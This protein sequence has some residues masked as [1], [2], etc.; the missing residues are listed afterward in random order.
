MALNALM[1][2][3]AAVFVAATLGVA[4]LV[5]G[6]PEDQP[7]AGVAPDH[8]INLQAAATELSPPTPPVV[9]GFTAPA[10]V[11]EKVLQAGPQVQPPATASDFTAD[12]PKIEPVDIVVQGPGQWASRPA[13]PTP[14]VVPVTKT[15][16]KRLELE[17][18][19]WR[20]RAEGLNRKAEAEEMRADVIGQ[21]MEK[22][23]A[24]EG[25]RVDAISARAEAILLRADAKLAEAK[26]MELEEKL[27]QP[28]ASVTFPQGADPRLYAEA[29]TVRS[30]SPQR[31]A[32]GDRIIAQF[33]FQHYDEGRIPRVRLKLDEEGRVN[34][35]S[36]L[37]LPRP[38]DGVVMLAGYDTLEA[39]RAIERHLAKELPENPV[40]VTVE[41][42]GDRA[43]PTPAEPLGRQS[44]ISPPA[45]PTPPQFPPS[46]VFK[47]DPTPH[48]ITVGD[49]LLVR[50]M[51]TFPEQPLDGPITV[52]ASGTLP[53]GPAYG[54]VN[55]VGMTLVEAEKA[56]I[57]KLAEVLND[58]DVQVTL[59]RA[60][61]RAKWVL[62]PGPQNYSE[63][64]A[65][66]SWPT[67]SQQLTRVISAK[68][69]AEEEAISSGHEP[70]R[71]VLGPRLFREGDSIEITRVLASSPRL[72]PGDSVVVS[73]RVR[74]SSR[75]AG[76]LS[77][78]LTQTESRV[79]T[80]PDAAQILRMERGV[81]EFTLKKTIRHR[82][83]LHITFYDPA[84]GKPFG[85]V[86]FGTKE[87]MESIAEW[88]LSYYL[89]ESPASSSESARTSLQNADTRPRMQVIEQRQG[90]SAMDRLVEL[91]REKVEAVRV[92]VQKLRESSRQVQLDLQRRKELHKEGIESEHRL[93]A[94]QAKL[95]EAQSRVASVEA[96]L[97]D[98]EIDLARAESE[99][100]VTAALTGYPGF[101]T[102]QPGDARRTRQVD[103][104]AEFQAQLDA[105]EASLKKQVQNL[106]AEL[107]K[108]D[109]EL[110]KRDAELA[111]RQV[112]LQKREIEEAKQRAELQKRGAEKAKEQSQTQTS[113][114]ATEKLKAELA[115][116]QA[117]LAKREEQIR[118]LKEAE[119][120]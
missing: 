110:Q 80:K 25:Q 114:A 86:Y 116:L 91:Q 59:L 32:V 84:S 23:G 119:I 115:K 71:I 24:S 109:T 16:R 72:E 41:R 18:D 1:K 15:G 120:K 79:G 12:R 54:R 21:L 99:Q 43:I 98:A 46:A 6:E 76:D 13:A 47:T 104:I 108:R 51:G 7:V 53:L 40:R 17:L 38:I 2:P 42:I 118:Q 111:K 27:K 26:A 66:R 75:D 8:A 45:V 11:D 92:E 44:S 35:L 95:H 77:L 20:L 36:G 58:V 78:Y 52:E 69:D 65:Y 39:A 97:K 81:Q 61:G 34:V 89:D 74:L 9:A 14:P 50:A 68:S 103:H 93:Q 88:D 5:A 30:T 63:R 48:R 33:Q 100:S 56:I 37:N 4:G 67:A 96:K 105:R 113:T 10:I 85:G 31:L 29:G 3:A 90:L 87:Q 22:T 64:A 112:E 102:T 101:S 19:H 82:G 94:A 70:V 107:S 28:T 57:E 73:G 117:E 83:A 60:A 62:P 49:Q 55:V 106:K